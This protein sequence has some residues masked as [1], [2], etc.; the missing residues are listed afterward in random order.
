MTSA[1][2]LPPGCTPA[3]VDGGAVSPAKAHRIALDAAAKTIPCTEPAC[4]IRLNSSCPVCFGTGLLPATED[5]WKDSE[6]FECAANLVE[7]VI[8]PLE[9]HE[10][11]E[12][13]LRPLRSSVM[14]MQLRLEHRKSARAKAAKS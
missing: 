1:G 7:F 10:D 12:D 2:S 9:V 5:E 6:L 14:A 13:L 4:R 3:M 8:E 11:F